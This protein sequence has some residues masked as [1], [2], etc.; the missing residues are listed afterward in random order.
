MSNKLKADDNNLKHLTLDISSAVLDNAFRLNLI[1]R[2]CFGAVYRV[3]YDGV[4]CAAK[5]R[6][7]DNVYKIEHF[8]YECLLHSKLRHPNIVRMLGVCYHNNNLDQPIELME[9]LELNL[10]FVVETFRVPLYVKLT[11]LQDVIRGL[12]YLH[13]RSPPIVHSYLN[14]NII[15]LTANLVAKIGG[16]TFSAEMVPKNEGLPAPTP[17]SVGNE[18]FKTSLYCGP[19]FDIYSFGFLIYEVIIE[20]PFYA[21]HKYLT[22]SP[23][24]KTLTVHSIN[25]GHQYEY[26]ID[27]AFKANNVSLKQLVT[28]CMNDNP[29]LR[30]SASQISEIITNIIR[31][32]S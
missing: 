25:L 32:K 21:G 27:Q 20:Q 13:T 16:F 4:T 1:S 31:G 28:D 5:H 22:D 30:P 17:H 14:M 11:L 6:C 12:E 3:P 8:K 15:L 7:F 9:L 18:L 26:N 23:I 10:L 29:N 19:P 2:G 24:G